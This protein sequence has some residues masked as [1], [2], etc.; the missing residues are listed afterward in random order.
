MRNI[1]EERSVVKTGRLYTEQVSKYKLLSL[2]CLSSEHPVLFTPP[3]ETYLY[4][5]HSTIKLA[6]V[7]N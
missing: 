7:F 5:S 6:K 1:P 4:F 3:K 2:R